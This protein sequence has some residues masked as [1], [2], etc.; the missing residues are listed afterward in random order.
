MRKSLNDL[1]VKLDIAYE[2]E[3]GP[4]DIETYT[5]DMKKDAESMD[6][7]KSSLYIRS[8]I[9]NFLKEPS[10]DIDHGIGMAMISAEE[11]APEMPEVTE[12]QEVEPSLDDLNEI[13]P[14]NYDDMEI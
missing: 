2:S 9:D 8:E 12:S 5:E 13:E 3:S 10:D 11:D 7:S 4:V 14:Y 1:S 6:F